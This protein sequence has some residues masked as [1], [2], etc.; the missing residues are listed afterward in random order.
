MKGGATKDTPPSE[1]SDKKKAK[2]KTVVGK[3]SEAEC[4]NPSRSA[5]SKADNKSGD[6]DI[7]RTGIESITKAAAGVAALSGP[8]KRKADVAAT[9][10]KKTKVTKPGPN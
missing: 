4:Q 5:K 2:K 1:D 8:S 6:N 3:D 9:A 7:D 10:P